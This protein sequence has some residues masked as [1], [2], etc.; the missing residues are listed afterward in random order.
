MSKRHIEHLREVSQGKKSAMAPDDEIA[1]NIQAFSRVRTDIFDTGSE[2]P[3]AMMAKKRKLETSRGATAWDGH[4]DS[5]DAAVSLEAQIRTLHASKGSDKQ[6]SNPAIGPAAPV[7][8]APVPFVAPMAAPVVA[9]LAPALM[10][11][12]LHPGNQQPVA[13][14]PPPSGASGAMVPEEHWAAMNPAPYELAVTV[15]REEPN[16][17]NKAWKLDG[18]THSL[19][20]RNDTT[21]EEVKQM[22]EVRTGLPPN[23]QKLKHATKGFLKDKD[24]LAFYNLRAGDAVELT[25]QQRGGKKK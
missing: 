8:N 2:T 14:A 23:L 15:A 5:V 13:L 1:A 10:H 3:E 6:Q 17:K 25:R 4:A 21:V 9:P 22:L 7:R 11:P 16:E 12:Y 20:V 24:S 18:S 19:S